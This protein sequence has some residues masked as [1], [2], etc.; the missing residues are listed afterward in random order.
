M[1]SV[2]S[3]DVFKLFTTKLISFSDLAFCQRAAHSECK[4]LF[5]GIKFGSVLF[6]SHPPS[7][8]YLQLNL[9]TSI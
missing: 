6:L 2:T 1:K 9:F 4:Y 5:E 3:E 8:P 7:K